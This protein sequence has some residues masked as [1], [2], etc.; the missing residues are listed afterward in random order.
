MTRKDYRLL[1]EAIKHMKLTPL[2]K[3]FVAEHLA[4]ALE[5]DNP[6]FNR[7]AFLEWAGVLG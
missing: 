3:I 2:N 6:R 4:D 5:K 1:A 7:E